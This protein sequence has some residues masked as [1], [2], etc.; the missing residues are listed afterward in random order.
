ML[1]F[2]F[3]DLVRAHVHLHVQVACRSAV[4]PDLS[5][6]S[7]ADAITAVHAWRNLHRQLLR[8]AHPPLTQTGIAG[9][10]DHLAGAAAARTRLLEI[11]HAA[12][13]HA[14]LPRTVAGLAGD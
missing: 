5:L 4:S 8:A 1:R 10:L 3:E 2:A 13:R 14:H 11:E 12:H 6:A 7:Q 9:I